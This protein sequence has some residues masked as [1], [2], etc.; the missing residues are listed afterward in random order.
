LELLSVTGVEQGDYTL[1]DNE[2]RAIFYDGVGRKYAA[3]A[4]I[5]VLKVKALQSVQLSQA[6]GLQKARLK[7][8]AYIQGDDPKASAHPIELR[9][10]AE[11]TNLVKSFSLSPNPFSTQVDF[12]ILLDSPAAALLEVFTLDGRRVYAENFDLEIGQQSIRVTA[13]ALPDDTVF[14]YRCWV[15]GAV[16]SGKLARM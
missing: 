15:N 10:D 4:S 8:E 6:L 13:G 1:F 2:L 16:F 11:G 5:M 3:G 12:N 14:L 9:F 7:P